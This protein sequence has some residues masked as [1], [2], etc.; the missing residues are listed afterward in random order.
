MEIAERCPDSTTM[1][2]TALHPQHPEVELPPRSGY[3]AAVFSLSRSSA[4]TR[5]WNSS[6][7]AGNATPSRNQGQ[8]GMLPAIWVN[9]DLCTKTASEPTTATLRYPAGRR[10]LSNSSH[11]TPFPTLTTTTRA[12]APSNGKPWNKSSSSLP[13]RTTTKSTVAPAEPVAAKT[14]SNERHEYTGSPG[15]QTGELSTSQ[16]RSFTRAAAWA[17]SGSTQTPRHP[18]QKSKKAEVLFSIG[19]PAPMSMYCPRRR[20]L[21]AKGKTKLRITNISWPTEAHE[22]PDPSRDVNKS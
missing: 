20:P 3:S 1:L 4:I 2:L 21:E 15:A 6:H 5:L 10:R 11:L 19:W 13:T 16:L 12:V 7:C 22:V 9:A 17:G 14:D 18:R 8:S